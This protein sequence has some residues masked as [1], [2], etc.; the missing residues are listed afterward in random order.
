MHE[1]AEFAEIV[2]SL[3]ASNGRRL[4]GS[5]RELCL[6]AFEQNAF[7][8]AACVSEAGRRGTTNSIGLLVR[9]VRDGDWDVPALESPRAPPPSP[10]PV[11]GRG[12]CFVCDHPADNAYL[13]AGQWYC[14]AHEGLAPG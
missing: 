7:G 8:F 4:N 10:E 6:Q 9:M 11:R 5:A 2:A 3:E 14:P 13:I 1:P 12:V